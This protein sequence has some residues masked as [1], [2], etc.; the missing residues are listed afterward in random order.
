MKVT[1]GGLGIF[2]AALALL[3]TYARA[4]STGQS[5][6]TDD[7]GKLVNLDT[8]QIPPNGIWDVRGDVRVFSSSEKTAYGTLEISKG[9]NNGLAVTLRGS[10]ASYL[11]FSGPVTIRHGGNDLELMFKSVPTEGRGL[12]LAGG[13]ALPHTPASHQLFGTA[14]AVYNV[15]V[16]FADAYLGAKGVFRDTAALGALCAGLD[17]H[18]GSGFNLVGDVAFPVVGTNTFNTTTGVAERKVVYGAALRF[19]P[20]AANRGN[21]SLDL[22]VTN[23]L[24]GTTGFSMSAALGNSVGVYAAASLRF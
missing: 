13:L 12:M 24:G 21:M 23:A 1:Q 6:R 8:D 16:S 2:C 18:V 5:Y 14:Q 22:G 10:V 7:R 20:F 15:P 17:V 11:N 3:S 19:A 4:Q 9:I